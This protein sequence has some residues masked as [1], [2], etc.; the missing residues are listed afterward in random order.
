M[1]STNY[2][3]VKVAH[4]NIIKISR[5]EVFSWT[6]W[7][8]SA[9]NISFPAEIGMTG[10]LGLYQKTI[11]TKRR[12]AMCEVCVTKAKT[13]SASKGSTCVCGIIRHCLRCWVLL[14]DN[15]L[16][17]STTCQAYAQGWE[18]TSLFAKLMLFVSIPYHKDS[19]PYCVV[20]HPRPG[21]SPHAHIFSL[22]RGTLFFFWTKY[23]YNPEM[24]SPSNLFARDMF[25]L[26]P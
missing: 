2:H 12:K 15:Y 11:S 13:S 10:R 9:A 22:T 17:S 23:K 1:Y 16:G 20:L 18:T 7:N 3:S 25:D 21:P 24:I 6:S 8:R 19:L 14:N 26:N 4:I 5:K